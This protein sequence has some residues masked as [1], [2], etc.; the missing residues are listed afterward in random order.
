AIPKLSPRWKP[1]VVHCNDWQ[2]SLTPVYLELFYVANPTWADAARVFTIH[3]L[4]YQGE[5]D[6]DVL[7]RT[8]LPESVF[9]FDQMEFYGR[10][11]FMKGGLVFSDLANTVSETYAKEIQTQEYGCRLE[12]LLRYLD[13]QGKMSGIVNG[14][15]YEE[16]APQ[17]DP[18]IPAHFS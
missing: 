3:N 5:F 15:D 9:T 18:R 12:G 1:D 4:A 2:T 13:G 16:Y 11:N 17:T 7:H 6:H 14:I 10:F 8:G